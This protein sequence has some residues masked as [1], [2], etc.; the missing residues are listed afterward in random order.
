MIDCGVSNKFI[1][2]GMAKMLKLNITEDVMTVE[3]P[4]TSMM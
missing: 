2:R 4:V 3:I 1:S